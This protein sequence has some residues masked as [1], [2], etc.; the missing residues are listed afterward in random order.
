VSRIKY[1]LTE[2]GKPINQATI[3]LFT[4]FN[5]LGCRKAVKWLSKNTTVDNHNEFLERYLN[6]DELEITRKYGILV[7]SVLPRNLSVGEC[8][9]TVEGYNSYKTG[10]TVDIYAK[11]Q[12][13]L[14]ISVDTLFTND[15][16]GDEPSYIVNVII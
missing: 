6:S 16:L 7:T 4:N 2:A 11:L 8:F 13:D 14:Y 3:K 5:T 9:I 10:S 1:D 15:Y 12:N